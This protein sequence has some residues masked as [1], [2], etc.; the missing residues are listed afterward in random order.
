MISGRGG[1]LGDV[2]EI[3]VRGE[4]TDVHVRRYFVNGKGAAATG[5]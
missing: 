3:G 1:A 5:I 4:K 2:V